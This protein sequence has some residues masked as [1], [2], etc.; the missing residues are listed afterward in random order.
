MSD[1]HV[2]T[3]W[4]GRIGFWLPLAA[5]MKAFGAT[6][7]GFA[8]FS[9]VCSLAEI[10]LTLWLG[11]LTVGRPALLAGTGRSERREPPPT[12]R[13]AG[14]QSSDPTSRL[15]GVARR[16][17]FPQVSGLEDAFSF[18]ARTREGRFTPNAA[19]RCFTSRFVRY[20]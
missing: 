16:S 8:S 13:S 18:G 14:P 12:A 2:Q 10:L 4:V 1:M 17:A 6:P 9:V 5:S 11:L 7:A 3:Q 15:H 19:A 20:S